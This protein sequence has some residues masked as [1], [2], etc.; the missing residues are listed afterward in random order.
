LIFPGL[1][2]PTAP[3]TAEVRP[4]EFVDK[5]AKMP[6]RTRARR[7]SRA[8]AIAAE[9]RANRHYRTTPR[10]PPY[11]PDE[12]LSYLDTFPEEHDPSPPPF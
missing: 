11:V 1:C 12:F 10:P 3:V 7:Q 6:Q 8:A 4:A 2:E 9:R 5:A